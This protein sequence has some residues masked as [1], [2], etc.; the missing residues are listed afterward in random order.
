VAAMSAMSPMEKIRTARDR[1]SNE[2]KTRMA[3]A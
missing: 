3:A 1:V 2:I